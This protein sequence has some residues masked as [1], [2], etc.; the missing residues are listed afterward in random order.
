MNSGTFYKF[1]IPAKYDQTVSFK[2][3]KRIS[4]DERSNMTFYE[5]IT[6][7]AK[8]ELRKEKQLFYYYNYMNYYMESIRVQDPQTQYTAFELKPSIYME[9]INVISYVISPIVFEYDLNNNE[10]IYIN[11][12]K[13]ENTYKFYLPAKYGSTVEIILSQRID[14]N[15]YQYKM[16]I[17]EL[18]SRYS[19]T[20]ISKK[21]VDL[22]Y[23]S[24]REYY[25]YLYDI[26]NRSTNYIVAELRPPTSVSANIKLYG[27][28]PPDFEYN[29]YSDVTYYYE[30]LSNPYRYKFYIS[31][32]KKETL[33]IVITSDEKFDRDISQEVIVYEYS[34][35]TRKIELNKY[36]KQFDYLPFLNHSYCPLMSAIIIQLILSNGL[37]LKYFLFVI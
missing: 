37:P 36:N 7:D 32:I 33:D 11:D 19:T 27:I 29:I 5:Y 24:T 26:Y 28:I 8:F 35:R 12:L 15:V 14:S 16:T 30:T 3:T 4:K 25:V 21:I 10:Y 13:Y 23:N 1:Y 22:S 31:V 20:E 17:Y 6:R 34:S 18:F 2:L 9:E